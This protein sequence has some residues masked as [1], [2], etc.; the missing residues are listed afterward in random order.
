MTVL[1]QPGVLHLD[2]KTPNTS[3][4]VCRCPGI[5]VQLGN[6]ELVCLN[7]WLPMLTRQTHAGPLG[8]CDPLGP[9]PEWPRVDCRSNDL[10]VFVFRSKECTVPTS[11]PNL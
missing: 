1:L 5:W 2:S 9:L 3:V 11:D 7:P 8:D 6:A 4:D 10:P